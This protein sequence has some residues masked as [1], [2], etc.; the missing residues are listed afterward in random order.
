ML[1][2]LQHN[3]KALWTARGGSADFEVQLHE[4]LF[5]SN[6]FNREMREAQNTNYMLCVL[7]PIIYYHIQ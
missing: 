2:I 4:S 7:L 1:S 5:Y 3:L 6:A